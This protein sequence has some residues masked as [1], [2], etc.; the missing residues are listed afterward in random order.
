VSGYDDKDI[1]K[2][3]VEDLTR[4]IEECTKKLK[5]LRNLQEDLRSKI[6]VENSFRRYL[7][8]KLDREKSKSDEP[9]NPV[10][11]DTAN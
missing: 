7:Q 4:R 2:D 10:S 5:E 8:Y 3:T 6:F 11:N 9:N 1:I